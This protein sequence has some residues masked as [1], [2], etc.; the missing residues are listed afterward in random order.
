M[1]ETSHIHPLAIRT[2]GTVRMLSVDGQFH[3]VLVMAEAARW[4]HYCHEKIATQY[5]SFVAKK[6]DS[7]EWMA[8]HETSH[9]E[10][11]RALDQA[12]THHRNYRVAR[13]RRQG[14]SQAWLDIYYPCLIVGGELIDVGES[15]DDIRLEDVDNAILQVGTIQRRGNSLLH[16]DVVREHS[17]TTLID[18]IETEIATVADYLTRHPSIVSATLA[19]LNQ[20]YHE[21]MQDRELMDPEFEDMPEWPEWA[22]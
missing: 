15:A 21:H 18:R 13:I 1:P 14:F 5:C 2:V 19:I 11:L 9:F 3:N 4:H 10:S 20:Q 8:T 22:Q 17:V 6:R 16:I 12:L 7:K